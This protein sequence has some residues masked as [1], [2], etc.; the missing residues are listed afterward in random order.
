MIKSMTAYARAEKTLDGAA[1]RIEMK[2]YNSRFLDIK[3]HMTSGYAVLEEKIKVR[4]AEQ[5]TRGR[6]EI[7]VG[8]Q[9][10][11]AGSK[12]FDVDL[13]RAAAYYQSL[14]KVKTVLS[15][16][17][18][19]SLAHILGAG[20][21]ITPCLNDANPEERL[22]S[23]T[24]DCLNEAISRLDDMRAREGE[25]LSHDFKERLEIIE[26][27]V[28]QI[29]EGAKTLLPQ[30]RDKLSERIKALTNGMVEIDPQ[31]ILQEAAF[32]ADKSDISEEIVRTR[33]HIRQFRQIM[34]L[35]E[36]GGR[37]LN[38]LLQEFNREFNT[39]GSKIGN[40]E[41][42]HLVVDAKSMLEKIR[43]QVQN[44]E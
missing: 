5:I 15:L 27:M 28:V 25:F 3:I 20:Q 24:G 41:I 40:A 31:R 16:K 26:T 36:P 9:D 39:M 23:I 22:W 37:K 12:T 29:D 21:M 34:D 33:S 43:E 4:I 18:E 10:A 30:Y 7:Y 6:I 32:L 38:F 1:V 11:L 19:I 42:S 13:E 14:V 35:N 17:E 2:S 8:I 44:I